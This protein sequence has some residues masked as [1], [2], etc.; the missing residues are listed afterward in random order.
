MD[1]NKNLKKVAV[2]TAFVAATSLSATV[3]SA[4]EEDQTNTQNTV[5]ETTSLSET[6]SVSD[7][8]TGWVEKD[9]EKYYYNDQ[10]VK[11][12]GIQTID[13]V[14]Y[15]FRD[16][17]SLAT[18]NGE[19]IWENRFGNYLVAYN[20][21]G[22]VQEYIEIVG[23]QWL[24]IN[25]KR[26]YYDS[27]LNP[28]KGIQTI[29]G[30]LY[31][32][33]YSGDLDTASPGAY[34]I[35][36]I[37]GKKIKVDDQGEIVE[38]VD[39][40]A[41][42]WIIFDGGKYYYDDDLKPYQG[43]RE[44][45]GKQYF[46]YSD[47]QLATASYDSDAFVNGDQLLVINEQGEI[48]GTAT[49]KANQWI[50][51]NGHKYCYDEDFNAYQGFREVDGKKYY[52]INGRLYTRDEPGISTVKMDN[53]LYAY[54]NL[55][56]VVEEVKVVANQWVY[57]N[58][59][60]YYFDN[61]LN[62]YQG[63][64]EIDGKRYFFFTD[65]ELAKASEGTIGFI[66]RNNFMVS[67]GED[68]E[69]IEYIEIV[70][71][72]WIDFNGNRYYYD[73]DL[74]PYDGIKVVD[75]Q[76]YYFENGQLVT[77]EYDGTRTTTVGNTMILYNR[78]GEVLKEVEIK[79]NQWIDFN[80][81]RYYY[82]ENLNPYK[83]VR[84]IDGKKYYFEWD[85]KLINYPGTTQSNGYL[86]AY[87]SNGEVTDEAKLEANKWIDFNG[88]RYYYD[89]NLNPYTGVREIDGKKYYFEWDGKLINY[90]GTTQSNGYLYA[91]NSNGEVTDEA[92]L[93]ANK[94]IDFN[95]KRYYYD[96]NLN[97]YT[98]VRE[99][100]GQKYYFEQDGKLANFSST[101]KIGNKLYA[102]DKNGKVT[103]EAE[104]IANKF[105]DF[106]G[107]KYCY[108]DNFEPYFGVHEV[109]GQLYY[110]EYTG[111]LSTIDADII[112]VNVSN[113]LLVAY[114]K[115]GKVIDQK[116]IVTG[117]WIEFY[118]DM[119][120]FD[121]TSTTINGLYTVDGK[122]YYFHGSALSK[123]S[124]GV[125]I[126]NDTLIYLK[127]G[128]VID[129]VSL[130]SGKVVYF[131]GKYYC[132]IEDPNYH[133][134]HPANGIIEDNGKEL[135]F[136]YGIL[137]TLDDG[138]FGTGFDND[139]V[140]IYNSK[141]EIVYKTKKV[142]GWNQ[143][144]DDTFQVDDWYYFSDE[145]YTV[146][147]IKKI[148]NK[149]YY[150]ENSLLMRSTGD[151]SDMFITNFEDNVDISYVI[152]YDKNG[153]IIEKYKIEKEG[154]LEV[155]GN[156]Y[157]FTSYGTVKD[158]ITTIDG[159]DYLFRNG[160]LV[161]AKGEDLEVTIDSNESAYTSDI[162][163]IAY[164]KNGVIK[165][166]KK[167]EAFQWVEFRGNTYYIIE[168][169]AFS[170]GWQEIDGHKYYFDA[171]GIMQKGWF[172][173]NGEE[174]YASEDGTIKAQWVESKYY[175]NADGKKVTGYQTIEGNKYYFDANGIKQTGWFKIDNA[176]YYASSNG[177][178]T[179]QWIKSTDTVKYYVDE[180]GK[181]L[182]GTQTIGDQEYYFDAQGRLLTGWVTENGKTSYY[183]ENGKATVGWL[184]LNNH[185][186]YFDKEGSMVTGNVTIDGKD[187]TFN[188]KGELYVP[189]KV[190]PKW[191]QE[192]NKW[193]YY[194]EDNEKVTG[195]QTIEGKKY[196][197]D[198]NGV[199]QTGWFKVNGEDYYATSS[200]SITAQWVGSGN[201][202][203]YVDADG[204]MVTGFQTI[205]GAKYYFAES[206]LMQKGWFKINGADYYATSSGAI[207]A[208]W[209]G[210]GNN[211]YF[212]DA[213]G[214]MLTGYQT[215]FGA[216]YYFAES[217]LM[218]KGWFKINGE[219]YYATSSG[220]ITAQWVGSGN[221]W[222]YVDENGKTTVGWLTLNGKKY[223][224]DQEGKM[225]T[226][227][228]NINGKDYTFNESGELT[229]E[230][231]EVK[232]GW[233]QSGNKW[234]YY[235]NNQKVTGY[236]TI[237]G[238]KY[239]FDANGVM[240]TGW[241]KIDNADYYAASSGEIKA[242]WVGSGNTWYYVDADGKMVT[243]FQIIVGAKYYF[244]ESG[245]MQKGWFKINGADYYAT[246]SGAI[247]A[248]WVGSGNTWYYVDADGKMVTGY[249]TIA[250]AKYYFAES[251]LMQTGWFKING[252][253]YYVASSGVISAQW[254]KSGN[255]WYYVDANG[256][257]VT[258]DYAI[259]GEVNRFDANGVW[260]G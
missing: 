104:I 146:N 199:M 230:T 55:G 212:V 39:I 247:N 203:Y 115:E 240:Q 46:F 75:G 43:I 61:D 103:A 150:F 122:E 68:G 242:Q 239:Y 182:T 50:Y 224:F 111:R 20:N 217:G 141:G 208:Q 258:G 73:S 13:K 84:E 87:N 51:I 124:N 23:N 65:G 219:D 101:V 74:N 152:V 168:N 56:E 160:K 155:N 142:A 116:T 233:V 10:G 140:F 173:I 97:P 3:V 176:D 14:T 119:Y 250:G 95:G 31:Y 180:N 149:E 257:M 164:D 52:F 174:Y 159:V 105:I 161:L 252:E 228:V 191:V 196:Y 114:D 86:Y 167:V 222:Y 218:Q 131:H 17:G 170:R 246:S 27:D 15:C 192:G 79:A 40:V 248:Q 62:P 81:R 139:Y 6:S 9:G 237:E 223:Y 28:Y 163:I 178:I 38:M 11:V 45:N 127:H 100:D 19:G 136:Q 154:W 48:L 132:Y 80:G 145:L 67:Y 201:N 91:Y 260:L 29:D 254:V 4:L 107:F 89:E 169:L 144:K 66:H 193:Y 229:V 121:S 236:Q 197:F 195:Y 194:N 5:V 82:D 64:K 72:Q 109:D 210:S 112:R 245:L 179:A 209:V 92:K 231:P 143:V 113:G 235:D 253:D 220:A 137:K 69:I 234:Y 70:G 162:Y 189:V 33:N 47:G 30:K 198:A 90:P 53:V 232:S 16:D 172:K 202:W 134:T 118:G 135:Y 126:Y 57:F 96:E 171:N 22:V 244:A 186:Y 83:G 18:F 77:F 125:Q 78:N 251:G 207:T 63:I 227:T 259:N 54:N 123:Y 157:Y 8:Q 102:Y 184:E 7:L 181:K 211:L 166:S 147:G 241:F 42:Q 216:K 88:K 76:K 188:E 49:I 129:K 93:E 204:K 128:E 133:Y 190:E 25:G 85:G 58:G 256:K 34:W 110:F 151:Q 206:G 32:F 21:Q 243:G 37:D 221:T 214:K 148:G 249:Q 185:K 24:D 26:F 175:V 60:Q 59:E 98:G 205:A 153:I 200:G 156:K 138:Q 44:I 106:N 225:V 158:G 35:S 117:Q 94:W 130:E 99:I 165:E 36:D 2:A 12:T 226:G 215:I 108:D 177:V 238:K 213:D 183:Q 71:N 255:N 41:N 187:Y 120:Y 1:N